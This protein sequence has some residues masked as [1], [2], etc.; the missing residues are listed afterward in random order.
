MTSDLEMYRTEKVLMDRYGD[1]VSLHAA[2][3]ADGLLDKGDMDGRSVWIRYKA[4]IE[5]LR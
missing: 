2:N 5:L 3:R 1:G 4:M